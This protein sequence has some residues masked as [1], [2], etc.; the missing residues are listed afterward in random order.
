MVD[1]FTRRNH[2]N[3]CFWT[4]CWNTGYFQA[5]VDGHNDSLVPRDQEVYVLNLRSGNIYLDRVR[6]VHLDRDLGVA[7][8]TAESMKDF[9]RRH[10]PS[11]YSDLCAYLHE[12][13]ESLFM[14]FEDIL[15]GLEALKSYE[16]LMNVVEHSALE[17]VVE[18]GFLTCHLIIQALRSHEMMNSMIDM[19]SAS[20]MPKWEY[21]WTLKQALSNESVLARAVAPLAFSSWV[22][23]RTDDHMFPLCDSPIMIRENTLMAVLSPRALLEIN[24]NNSA[25]EDRWLIRDGIS[26]SKY[27][28]FRRRSI[29]NAFKEVIFHDDSELARWRETRE[30][31]ARSRSLSD[32]ST[33]I[34]LLA[35]AAS[36]VIWAIDG[37][38]RFDDC[39]EAGPRR[40]ADG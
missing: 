39:I 20:G 10:D 26:A 12:H 6:N 14:D 37:F 27:R 32:R 25:P 34:Q 19:M 5:L 9:C 35:E 7:E 3:P 33:Y 17:S 15:T 28:E 4:A 40:N 36:R 8:I 24:L 21:F 23:F 30:F 16:A 2:Y 22:I 29:N 38:G 18:K 11:H 31:K 13:P 1:A